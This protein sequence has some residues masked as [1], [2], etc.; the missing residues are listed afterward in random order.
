MDLLQQFFIN[1]IQVGY[2]LTHC[3]I[4]FL[5]SPVYH[6]HLDGHMTAMLKLIPQLQRPCQ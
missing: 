4:F 6:C 3:M 5:N 2:K 1:T